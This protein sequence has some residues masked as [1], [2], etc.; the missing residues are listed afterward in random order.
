MQERFNPTR[1]DVLCSSNGFT[2]QGT[3]F[4]AHATVQPNK[5][6]RLALVQRFNPTR[7]DVLCSSNGLTQKRTAF[8]ARETVQPNK[9]RCLALEQ[10]PPL[11]KYMVGWL[12]ELQRVNAD[13]S[14]TQTLF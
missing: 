6:R 2:Q 10:D 9:G 1:D 8:S 13:C 5:G 3:A 4:S 7:D 14:N 11:V 12:V